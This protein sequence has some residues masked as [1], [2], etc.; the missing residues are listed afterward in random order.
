MTSQNAAAWVSSV[1]A[2]C[3]FI[4][5]LVTALVSVAFWFGAATTDVGTLRNKVVSLESEL[6]DLRGS[7]DR[8]RQTVYSHIDK[9]TGEITGSA[10]LLVDPDDEDATSKR[11]GGLKIVNHY[12]QLHLNGHPHFFQVRTKP[13]IAGQA[14]SGEVAIRTERAGGMIVPAV[15]TATR[16]SD[17]EQRSCICELLS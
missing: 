10:F 14:D 6:S 16:T 2:I 7:F 17:S 3:A 11:K 8:H 13:G 12:P 1:A 15:R 9:E 5:S 4:L